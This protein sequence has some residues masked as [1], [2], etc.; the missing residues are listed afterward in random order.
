MECFDGECGGV[1]FPRGQ[2]ADRV[3]QVG[4]RHVFYFFDSLSV[5]QLCQ[6]RSAN[7]CRRAAVCEVSRGFDAIVFNDQRESQS[8]AANRVLLVGDGVRVREFACVARMC[9]MIFELGR[10]GHGYTDFI[11]IRVKACGDVRRR[12]PAPRLRNRRRLR[13]CLSRN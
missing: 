7:K 1:M 13:Y 3:E 2:A 9:E 6:N 8:I 5:N 11:R 10:I 12:G 4:A